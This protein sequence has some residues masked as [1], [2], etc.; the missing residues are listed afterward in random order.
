MKSKSQK[1][2]IVD[3]I[4][5][6]V[7]CG[8]TKSEFND[9]YVLNGDSKIDDVKYVIMNKLCETDRRILLLYAYTGSLRTTG[10]YLHCSYSKVSYL[11]KD[12]REKINQELA[13]L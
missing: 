4:D 8:K 5:D 1:I 11:L 13:R 3:I 12:I 7:L 6:Y 2:N 9:D 10:N